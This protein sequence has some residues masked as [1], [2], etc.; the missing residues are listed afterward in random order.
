[1]REPAFWWRETGV[2]ARLLAPVAALYGAVAG[3][4]LKQRGRA[5]ACR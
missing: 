4:R 3:A 2:A 1:M 5:P